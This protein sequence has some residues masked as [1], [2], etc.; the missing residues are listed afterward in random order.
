MQPT[1]HALKQRTEI[2]LSVIILAYNRC[3]EV[4]FTLEKVKSM[5]TLM[6]FDLEIIVVDN[7]SVDGT[8]ATVAAA[9]P[10][11]NLIR[12]E[13]NNGIAGWNEG[14]KAAKG[15]Y[16]FVL[17]DDSHIHS[18]LQDAVEHM[19]TN[20]DTGILAM[21]ILDEQLKTDPNLDPETAW[22]DGDDI[23]GFIGCGAMIRKDLYQ[24]IGGFA[25]WI[26]V[27]THEFEYAIRCLNAGYRVR[28]CGKC[29]VVHRISKLNR[30]PQKMR[31]YATRNEM[32]IVYKYFKTGKTKY[33]FRVLINN[34]KF[35]KREGLAA[36]YYV[37]KGAIAFLKLKHSLQPQ[38]VTRQ[39]QD[40]YAH[41]FWATKPVLA[42][43]NNKLNK[44]HNNG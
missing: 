34:L 42:N 43:I 28:F 31:I 2:I 18:G 4:L 9:F 7:A 22:K 14:F 21:Q 11:I 15:K 36:G 30:L 41:N 38:F 39:V 29:V 23:A 3:S 26:Y 25:E 40:F 32:A 37:L 19:E 27:Y 12:K 8:Y 10:G 5:Q 33:L 6:P 17:D 13:E 1:D 35:I 24:K 20:T 16:I 44:K